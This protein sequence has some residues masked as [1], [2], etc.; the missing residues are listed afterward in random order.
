M[1]TSSSGWDEAF[2][3]LTRFFI[4]EGT[5]GDTLLR[6]SQLACQAAPADFAGIT[7]L[8]EGSTRTGVFTDPESPEIDQAQYD[9]GEGPCLDAFRK[10]AVFRIDA[11]SEDQRWPAFGRRAA[12]HGIHSTLSVPIIA[13]DEGM[14]ALN[15]YSHQL[16]AFDEDCAQR[17]E[18]FANQ[19]GF[20]LANAQVY[21]DAHQLSENLGQ[22]MR[23]RSTI[24]QAVGILMAPGGRSPEEAFQ[25]LVRVSQR[26]NRKLR[27]VAA[28]IVHRAASR[29][30]PSG[31]ER[32]GDGPT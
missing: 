6:L 14:G 13:R 15:L 11:T 24:D 8:V 28:E 29:R 30:P 23:S 25:L 3:A 2:A 21:W 26:E 17:M 18:S 9:S 16:A 4:N 20:V 5:L 22:A 10:R 1:V 12:E 27:D 19:A 32:S 31:S 7:M